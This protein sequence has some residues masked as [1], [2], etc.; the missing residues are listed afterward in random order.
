VPGSTFGLV[1]DPAQTWY[2][3]GNTNHWF[4]NCR[5]LDD[6]DFEPRPWIQYSG[7]PLRRYQLLPFYER[8]Q[9]LCGLGPFALYDL[10][11]CRAGLTHQPLDVDPA[12]LAHKVVQT[13][14]VLSF[15]ELYRQRLEVTP[16]VRVCFHARALRLATNARADA[17]HSVDV[18]SVDGGRFR[19]SARVFVLASGGIENP[20]LLLCS[21]DVKPNGLGNDHDLV[22][23]FFMEH[24]FV[25]IPLGDWRPRRDVVFHH[26]RQQVSRATVWG[27][28]VL[29]EELARAERLTGMGLW[30]QRVPTAAPAVIS[31]YRIKNFLRGRGRLEAPMAE[32]RN[33]LLD[34]GQL[35]KHVGRRLRRRPPPEAAAEGYALRVNMEQPPDPENRIRLS[36]ERDRFGQRG[37]DLVLRLTDDERRR[38]CRSLRIVAGELGLNGARIARQMGV[39]LR[40]G[41]IGFFFHHMG[42]TRMHPDPREGVVDGDARVHGVSNLFVAG[43]SLFP[44]GGTAMPTLTIVALALRLARHLQRHHV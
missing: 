7:W 30:F 37:V 9:L 15:G 19:V 41:Q 21:D 23:R 22:G 17:V 6:V 43:S 10:D 36:S 5:P 8:A 27:Q 20:R 25:D 1:V 12:K 14:P 39:M 4:G 29:S 44:A 2:L 40:T 26:G 34:P 18:A 24:P 28:L 32:I 31:A 13:C 33:V 38:H 35:L 16:N 11:T 3:G 42:T